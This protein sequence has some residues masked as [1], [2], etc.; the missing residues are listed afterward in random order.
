M[1][2]RLPRSIK[3][4]SDRVVH[5]PQRA[6]LISNPGSNTRLVNGTK[7]S[8]ACQCLTEYFQ[9]TSDSRDGIDNMRGLRFSRKQRFAVVELT[10]LSDAGR[11]HTG[12]C[13]RRR[14]SA[15]IVSC[16]PDASQRVFM[17]GNESALQLLQLQK[18]GHSAQV[19]TVTVNSDCVKLR[20]G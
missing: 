18:D 8:Q 4:K 9:L 12:S 2:S 20:Q 13:F 3:D 6:L 15:N 10:I 14:R 16:L 19:C 17:Q 7:D 5:V 11:S 1:G